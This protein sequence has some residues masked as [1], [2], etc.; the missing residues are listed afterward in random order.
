MTTSSNFLQ[1]IAV[2]TLSWVAMASALGQTTPAGLWRTVDD[3]EPGKHK[4]LIRI[5]EADGIYTGRVEKVLDPALVGKLCEKCTGA[6]ANKPLEGLQVMTGMRKDDNKF[7][8][9]EIV[10]P[11]GGGVYRCRMQLG[12]DGRSLEVRGFIGIALLGRTQVWERVE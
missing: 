11:E 7:G 1:R 2:A 12:A 4:V 6:R 9:G 5:V 8:G 3:V 10:D